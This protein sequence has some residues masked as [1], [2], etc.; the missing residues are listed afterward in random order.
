[1]TEKKRLADCTAQDIAE[2]YSQWQRTKGHSLRFG[3]WVVNH[4]VVSMVHDELFYEKSNLVAYTKCEAAIKAERRNLY[5]E[6]VN[7]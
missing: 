7:G 2:L 1:M 4:T 6:N 5:K 3:Q